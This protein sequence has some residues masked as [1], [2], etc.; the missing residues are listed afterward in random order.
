MASTIT[1]YSSAINVNFPVP[2]ADNDSQGFRTN[3]TKIKSAL[4]V[5]S[6]E[7]SALQLATTNT[8]DLVLNNYTS[9]E[10]FNLGTSLDDGTVVFLTDIDKPVYYKNSSDTW[11]TF[12]GTSGTSV[13]L[14]G[15]TVVENTAEYTGNVY[16]E[17]LNVTSKV[18]LDSSQSLPNT[19]TVSLTAIS[20]YFT[21][22]ELSSAT[23]AVGIA[24]QIKTFM[25]IGDEGDM[26][27]SVDQAGWKSSITTGTI[28]F[29][30][31]G[32][33]CTLQYVNDRWYCIGQNGVSFG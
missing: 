25:M 21:T 28:T 14:G 9:S 6:T 15:S 16:A 10:L 12:A 32:D 4:S 17:T 5:A 26:I 22:T 23:L 3:Y 13:T 24:G 27:I 19:G 7:I 18:L 30:N 29:N 11:H 33:G 8:A 2:G 1:N 20:S 31:I